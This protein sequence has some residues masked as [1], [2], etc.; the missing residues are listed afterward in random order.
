MSELR[1]QILFVQLE[2]YRFVY[3]S[4]EI[5]AS[6]LILREKFFHRKLKSHSCFLLLF[7][8]MSISDEGVDDPFKKA[9]VRLSTVDTY[10]TP[11]SPGPTRDTKA[12]F[13]QYIVEAGH[14]V[15][16]QLLFLEGVDGRENPF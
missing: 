1:W 15:S 8:A 10:P 2:K 5:Q 16:S 6:L 14:P 12:F 4:K 13:S 3:F 11:G 7:L 9:F